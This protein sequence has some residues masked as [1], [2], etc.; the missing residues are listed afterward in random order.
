M[1][2]FLRFIFIACV[3]SPKG[4][5]RLQSRVSPRVSLLSLLSSPVCSL[6]SP[7]SARCSPMFS[8]FSLLTLLSPLD[9][10]G[11]CRVRYFLLFSLQSEP[12]LLLSFCP[13]W[14][15]PHFL[16]VFIFTVRIEKGSQI[17]FFSIIIWFFRWFF[18]SKMHKIIY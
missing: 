14:W 8:L 18:F 10:F 7:H 1:L 11:S 5:A 6:F 2:Q 12:I 17:F 13:F 9:A 16:T 15:Q 3:S 4:L